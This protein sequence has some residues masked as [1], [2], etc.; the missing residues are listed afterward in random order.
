MKNSKIVEINKIAG[1]VGTVLLGISC[2]AW[3]GSKHAE[4]SI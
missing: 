4:S 3:L 1:T 2:I